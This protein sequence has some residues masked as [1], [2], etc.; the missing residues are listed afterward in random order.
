MYSAAIAEVP[1]PLRILQEAGNG[2]FTLTGLDIAE[3]P[4]PLRILQVRSARK[5]TSV[6]HLLPKT[7]REDG[8]RGETCARGAD[9]C[10]P[11]CSVRDLLS[12]HLQRDP[13]MGKTTRAF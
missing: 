11:C 1:D 6:A 9:S 12:A 7:F 3:V 2:T 10:S 4:D 8:Y 13:A 5:A